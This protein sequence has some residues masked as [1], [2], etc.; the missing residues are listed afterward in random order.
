MG[1]IEDEFDEAIELV[2]KIDDK[3]YLIEAIIPL[4]D[5]NRQL[6]IDLKGENDYFSTLAGF[7]TNKLEGFPSV[8]SGI[9]LEEEGISLKVVE[10]DNTRIKTIKMEIISK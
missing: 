3:T 7:V 9:V 2:K 4:Q 5:L 6:D 10:M 8:D 1:D